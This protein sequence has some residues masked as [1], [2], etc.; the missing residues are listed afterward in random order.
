M[1]LRKDNKFLERKKIKKIAVEF[2]NQIWPYPA[3]TLGL[4]SRLV[5]SH[6]SGNQTYPQN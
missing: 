5:V 4:G 3:Y 6:W 1:K 2:Y